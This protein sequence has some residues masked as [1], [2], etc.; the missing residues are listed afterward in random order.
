MKERG[1]DPWELAKLPPFEELRGQQVD[2]RTDSGLPA[3][4]V[5][6]CYGCS[7]RAENSEESALESTGTEAGPK[8]GPAEEETEEKRKDQ[9]EKANAIAGKRRKTEAT[10]TSTS[11]PLKKEQRDYLAT[12][13]KDQFVLPE[14][15]SW[16]PKTAGW[17]DLYSGERGVADELAKEYGCWSLCFD[18]EH[19]AAE[20]L[21]DKE[22]R[23]KIRRAVQ[24]GC[25]I[26]GGG[27]PVCASF[28]TAITPPVRTR[29][30]PYGRKDVSEAMQEKLRKGNDMAL[31]TFGIIR[32]F[33]SLSLVVWM[34]NPALSWMFRLQEWEALLLQFPELNYWTVDYCQFGAP[35]RKRTRFA[36]NGPLRLQKVLC[37]GGHR[38]QILRGRS[39][40]H[41]QNWT[42]VAQAY[43]KD[44]CKT[45]AASLM[46]AAGARGLVKLDAASCARCNQRIGEASHPGPRASWRP[47]EG[48][49]YDV[50]LVEAR[51]KQIQVRVWEGFVRWLGTRLTPDAVRSAMAFPG[52]L[53][54]LLEQY[55][56]FQFQ[57]GAA[58]Y[59]YRHLVVFTQQD[60]AGIKPW[61]GGCWEMIARWEI[62][63][64]P[65]HR[66]P[67]PETLFRAMF[68][69]AAHWGWHR[70]ASVLGISFFGIARPGEPLAETRKSLLLPS[71]LLDVES[72]TAFL[73]ISSPKTRRR[74]GGRIQHLTITDGA[75]VAYLERAMAKIPRSSSLFPGSPSAFRRRWDAILVALGVPKSAGLTPGGLRGGGCVAAFHR[76]TELSKI[77]WLMR[78][79]HVQTLQAYLQEVAASSVV[80]DLPPFARRR[81]KAASALFDL[82]I[83]TAATPS[84]A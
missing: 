34:E 4:T 45:L 79:K 81:V 8:T 26:G 80:P 49:L 67:L 39:K 18:I 55:G 77:L 19:S 51:T 25:F 64:P 63:E 84:D 58:L 29:L 53:S 38:H 24:L 71:D 76:G 28:S 82:A 10:W 20:D 27:G 23:S 22:L 37:R 13:S 62:R 11:R 5:S 44:V 50:P 68:T 17:L 6:P 74:G 59:S 54:Q 47:R 33:L 46:V 12:F 78:I 72:H 2:S 7:S 70:F 83:A 69:I 48:A 73:R 30:F 40:R 61:L 41:G 14:G 57:E 60:V 66:T 35:W 16:P 43:P 32:L 31:W 52:L 56:N 75:F 15:A 21:F 1:L 42:R 3:E 65:S 9:R 36:T